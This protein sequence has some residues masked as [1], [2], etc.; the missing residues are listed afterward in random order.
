MNMAVLLA[1]LQPGDTF[2]A[3]DLVAGGHFTHGMR[4]NFSGKCFKASHYAVRR[5]DQIID[6]DA[7]AKRP[8]MRRNWS[9]PAARLSS[10]MGFRSAFARSPTG[11][12]QFLMVDMAHFRASWPAA[13][14]PSR[15][16]RP[17]RHLDH[18]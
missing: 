2:L 13:C 8:S 7:L 6:M 1:R 16:R 3:L 11:A 17:T 15:C 4:L 18:A 10:A 12:A 5:D 9:S 14:I